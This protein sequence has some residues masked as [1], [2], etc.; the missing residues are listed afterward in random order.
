MVGPHP[1]EVVSHGHNQLVVT[2]PFGV[3]DS[4]P[5]VV[6]VGDRSSSNAGAPLFA[7]DPPVVTTI[8]PN[9]FASVAD[10]SEI[11]FTG[12]NF[13]LEATP[14]SVSIGGVPCL[15]PRW[16]NDN[17]LTCSPGL[18][19]VGYKNVTISIAN[20]S[21][22]AFWHAEEHMIARV[23][24]TGYT[25]LVGEMC[26]PC[27]GPL[28]GS[29]CP[30]GAL[31]TE[32]TTASLPGW[33]R[34]D[35]SG[36]DRSSCAPEQRARG[37]C[38]VFLRCDQPEACLG[39]NTC[40][41]G[42]FGPRCT[43]CAGACPALASATT[44]SPASTATIAGSVSAALLLVV[45][46]IVGYCVWSGRRV[47]ACCGAHSAQK[48]VVSTRLPADEEAGFATVGVAG[49]S[50][51]AQPAPHPWHAFQERIRAE[52]V[53]GPDVGLIYSVAEA[54]VPAMG[55][56]F[57]CSC[58]IRHHCSNAESRST[59]VCSQG[60]STPRSNSRIWW[61]WLAPLCSQLPDDT[62]LLICY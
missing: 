25:G 26:A 41:G 23:C 2:A 47:G 44:S 6:S 31:S 18:D 22:P 3:G 5:V 10:T 30:G 54:L 59:L 58:S 56:V 35:A 33:W 29:S 13:G 40:A 27:T 48:A 21:Q 39:N 62:P 8:L 52:A 49:T 43:S 51:T 4:N 17:H 53:P 7:Y 45:A 46:G 55:P 60:V 28:Q 16:T 34:T 24:P 1:A 19:G 9:L 36:D 15:L 37:V 11:E 12:F 32:D 42:Y 61:R 38:P 50:S 14:L 20:R 57:G